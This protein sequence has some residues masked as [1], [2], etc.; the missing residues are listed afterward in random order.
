MVS[1]SVIVPGEALQFHQ[2]QSDGVSDRQHDRGTR[3]WRESVQ[4]RLLDDAH[5]KNDVAETTKV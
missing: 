2:Y 4:A 5:I 1:T 3:R